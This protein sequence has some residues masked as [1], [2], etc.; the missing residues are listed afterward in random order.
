MFSIEIVNH[1]ESF[2]LDLSRIQEIAEC[3]SKEV[4]TP[5]HGTIH[6]AF[7]SDDEI[8]TLNREYRSIDKTT[9]VLSFHYFDDFS[10]LKDDDIAGEIILSESRILAQ[11]IDHNHTPR[12]EGEILLIHGLL[13]IL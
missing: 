4:D 1:S 10:S 9:D 13:H 2:I 7:L 11:A 6:V 3:V 8:Q 12:E 5:Q